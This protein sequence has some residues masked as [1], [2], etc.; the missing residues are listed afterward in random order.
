MILM[1]HRNTS[2]TIDWVRWIVVTS[3]SPYIQLLLARIR[4][5]Q[6]CMR[7]IGIT[8]WV[9]NII[10]RMIYLPM[11][12]INIFPLRIVRSRSRKRI[13]MRPMR[14]IR[15]WS[16]RTPGGVWDAAWI[17]LPIRHSR[18]DKIGYSS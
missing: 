4:R 11:R 7:N 6:W 17:R 8:R 14:R 1:Q 5:I 12:R 15:L 18:R 9:L 2:R 16:Q 13:H 3:R 10:G